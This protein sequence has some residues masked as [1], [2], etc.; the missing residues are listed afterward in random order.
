M[1]TVNADIT[2]NEAVHGRRAMFPGSFNPF[3]IGHQSLVERGLELF[4][5]VVVAAGISSTKQVTEEEIIDRLEPIR[6]LYAGNP[7]VEV[8]HY[9]GLTAD[10]ARR[11][12]CKF[13]LR[14]I[15]NTIDMEYE[16]SLA[17]I[18]RRISGIETVL[19]FTLPELAAVSSSTVRELRHYGHDVSEFMPADCP[20]VK[21][22]E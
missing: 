15:R 8:T 16:R 22:T 12:G 1:H 18:N 13:L 10:A 5:T 6:A 14:G 2:D 3:T 20:T 19:L 21:P 17:D 9:T 7:R 4:D 11:H